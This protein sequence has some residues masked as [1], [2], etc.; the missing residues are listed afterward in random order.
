MKM[1]AKSRNRTQFNS[2]ALVKVESRSKIE[3][4][5][6]AQN[7]KKVPASK[8]IKG[9]MINRLKSKG[10]DYIRASKDSADEPPDSDYDSDAERKKEAGAKLKWI[11][12]HL[13]MKG[14]G[15]ELNMT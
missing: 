11:D 12:P 9:N 8:S 6:Y 5:L 3:T 4:Y 13:L 1:G 10:H 2:D 14:V 7:I 15:R